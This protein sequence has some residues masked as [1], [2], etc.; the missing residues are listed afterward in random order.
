MAAAAAGSG[1]GAQRGGAEAAAAAVVAGMMLE[2]G[3]NPFSDPSSPVFLPSGV[4]STFFPGPQPTHPPAA[5]PAAATVFASASGDVT[6]G[7]AEDD[8]EQLE[9]LREYA[10]AAAA[11]EE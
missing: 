7:A 9:L 1:S 5:H 11:L 10:E 8:H 6:T 2:E 3:E 4:V